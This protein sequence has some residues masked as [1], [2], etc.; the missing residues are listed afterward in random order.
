MGD[1]YFWCDSTKF[2]RVVDKVAKD[3]DGVEPVFL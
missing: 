2:P 1:P 3:I